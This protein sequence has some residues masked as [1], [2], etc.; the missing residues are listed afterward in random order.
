M[1][2]ETTKKSSGITC[3]ELTDFITLLQLPYVNG[4]VSTLLFCDERRT[5]VEVALR[6]PEFYLKNIKRLKKIASHMLDSIMKYAK[7]YH[8]QLPVLQKFEVKCLQDSCSHVFHLFSCP[9]LNR[10][11]TCYRFSIGENVKLFNIKFEI[12][13]AVKLLDTM[14]QDFTVTITNFEEYIRQFPNAKLRNEYIQNHFINE[15]YD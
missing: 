8:I 1:A 9:E 2:N 11:E 7:Y 12:L 3:F 4:E 15:N 10:I 14:I 13:S 6:Q 5:Y